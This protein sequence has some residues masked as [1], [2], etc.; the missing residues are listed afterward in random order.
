MLIA[1]EVWHERIGA[2]ACILDLKIALGL[3]LCFLQRSNRRRT[4]D[5]DREIS[6]RDNGAGPSGWPVVWYSYVLDVSEIS[7]GTG[8]T[9]SVG[10]DVLTAMLI[11]KTW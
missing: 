8:N 4:C 1:D 7:S 9:D 2:G 10:L 5:I 11:I 6:P 3:S